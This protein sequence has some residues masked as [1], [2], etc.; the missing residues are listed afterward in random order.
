MYN[1]NSD[2]RHNLW[3]EIQKEKAKLKRIQWWDHRLAHSITWISV[4]ASFT[5][6]IMV[7]FKKELC[8]KSILTAVIAGI[9]GLM[10]AIDKAFDFGRRSHW[11]IMFEI[12]LQKILDEIELTETDTFELAKKYRELRESFE[13]SYFKIGFFSHK[14]GK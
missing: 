10:I 9:P 1:D 6:T 14:Q 11:D 13:S 4:L 12:G 7:A 5:A 8:D 2:P 3:M